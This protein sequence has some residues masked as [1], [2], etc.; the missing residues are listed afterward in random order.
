MNKDAV[1][2]IAMGTKQGVMGPGAT[3]DVVSMWCH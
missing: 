1:Q 2:L 3:V